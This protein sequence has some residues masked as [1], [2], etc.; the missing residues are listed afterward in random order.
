MRAGDFRHRVDILEYGPVSQDPVSGAVTN[1]W[2]VRFPRVPSTF[3]PLSVRDFTAAAASQTKI[4]ARVKVRFRP[5]LKNQMR[6]VH[7]GI[8]YKIEGW[9]PDA[10]SGREY[11]TA[12]LSH[13]D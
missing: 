4:V 1:N 5:G 7:R 2:Y 8:S 3:E 12:A 10:E 6:I 9:L 13:V 11:W